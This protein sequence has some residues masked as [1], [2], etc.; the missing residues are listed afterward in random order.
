MGASASSSTGAAK[1]TSRVIPQ[2]YVKQ[3]DKPFYDSYDGVLFCVDYNRGKC[4]NPKCTHWHHCN[5]V[6][7]PKTAANECQ[8]CLHDIRYGPQSKPKAMGPTKATDSG[9]SGSSV[10]APSSASAQKQKLV[11]DC[12]QGMHTAALVASRP[13]RQTPRRAGPKAGEKRPRAIPPPP[14]TILA[15]PDAAAGPVEQKRA[16]AGLFPIVKPLVVAI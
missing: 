7:C 16:R 14:K 11:V 2:G 8:S 13:P 1:S 5:F 12:L 4:T 3:V 10:L 9:A 6:G 15:G